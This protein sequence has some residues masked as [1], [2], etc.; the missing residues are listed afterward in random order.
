MALHREPKGTKR[1]CGWITARRFGLCASRNG[2]PVL[3]HR[4]RDTK[5]FFHQ[6]LQD[7]KLL[8]IS[9]QST[10]STLTSYELICYRLRSSNLILAP[11][12]SQ[13]LK[14]D[15]VEDPSSAEERDTTDAETVLKRLWRKGLG[16]RLSGHAR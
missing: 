14:E 4:Q 1:C 13:D 16:V 10:T 8:A 5:V 15:A 9:G 3:V 6:A 7:R 2:N 11:A 12:I